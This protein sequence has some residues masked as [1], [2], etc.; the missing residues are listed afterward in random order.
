MTNKV[1]QTYTDSNQL[2]VSYTCILWVPPKNK[3]KKG[4]QNDTLGELLVGTSTG[5]VH[6]WNLSNN[7]ITK[8]YGADQNIK[9]PITSICINKRSDEIYF[10]SKTTIYDY[11]VFYIILIYLF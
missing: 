8:K 2:Q 11:H 1:R 5:E 4:Y 7:E 9:D 6:L 10:T 3:R